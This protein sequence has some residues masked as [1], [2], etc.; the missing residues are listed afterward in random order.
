MRETEPSG[1]FGWWSWLA[2]GATL[3]FLLGLGTWQLK[4]KHWKETLL[5]EIAARAAAPAATTLLGT[6][7]YQRVALAG[8]FEPNP[9]RFVFIS[10]PRQ[11]SGVGGPGYWLFQPFH[12]D[13]PVGGREVSVFVNRGFVPEAA[14]TKPWPAPERQIEGV[15][16]REE[17]R[18]R[19]S[20]DNDVAKNVY[21]VRSPKEFM[22]G[23]PLARSPAL[24]VYID[25]TGP[26]P[27]AGL[28]LPLV[29]K[30]TI[31]NRH[32]EYA[33][34]WYALAVTLLGIVIAMSR[35]GGRG[36]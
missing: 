9:Q 34:T 26:V 23:L 12:L 21:Y 1:E 33:L 7:E 27:A 29:G 24:D 5:A 15:V 28:P 36:S 4:R 2:I 3:A 11:A 30:I 6:A 14:K 17:A 22:A 8:R 31:P 32:L 35:R 19:F 16:R 20:N 18:G 25:M 10:V 13:N